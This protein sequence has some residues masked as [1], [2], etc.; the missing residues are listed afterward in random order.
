MSRS[1]PSTATLVWLVPPLL[2]SVIVFAAYLLTHPYPAEGGGL[3]LAMADAIRAHGYRLPARVPHYTPN[4][5]PFGYPPLAFYLVAFIRDGFGVGPLTLTRYLPGL[6]TVLTVVPV[7][8]LGR[9]VFAGT[10]DRNRRAGLAALVVAVSPA[11]FKWHLSAGGI[12]RAPAFLFTVTGLYVGIR[13]FR[14][15]RL[16]WAGAGAVLFGLTCLTHPSYPVFFATSYLVFFLV[17]DRSLAG[18]ARGALV[19]AGG[20]LLALPWWWGVISVHGVGLFTRTA[21]S[22]LG[23][24]Q[25]LFWFPSKFLYGR[26]TRFLPVW[27]VLTLVGVVALTLR[28]RYFLPFWFAATVVMFPKPRFLMLVGAFVVSGIVFDWLSTVAAS[29]SETDRGRVSA[30]GGRLARVS[31]VLLLLLSAYGVATGG[32]YASNYGPIPARPLDRLQQDPMPSYIDGDDMT[33][34]RW[35]RERTPADATVLVAGDAA[36]WFPVFA[37]RTVVASPWGAEWLPPD[38]RERQIA[39]Y[40]ESSTCASA[41]CLRKLLARD[42]VSPDYVYLTREGSRSW[43]A[44]ETLTTAQWRGMLGRLNGSTGTSVVFRNRDVAVV[45][46]ESSRG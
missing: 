13:L 35:M 30:D 7:Y 4:G 1:R 20:L 29:Q 46:V 18:L 15:K 31:L 41:R 27:H 25:G 26:R 17:F 6:V 21:G 22:R 5:I 9:E 40:R 23:I 10:P 3:Y 38:R 36:E 34:M 37:E 32:L 2:A 33:A 11:V 24:G 12:V 42:D 44:R 16:R 28:K 19:A 14:E 45:K 39:L 43:I 8:F